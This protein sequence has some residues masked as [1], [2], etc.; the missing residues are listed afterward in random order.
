MPSLVAYQRPGVPAVA[1][2]GGLEPS[3]SREI[4]GYSRHAKRLQAMT[5]IVYPAMEAHLIS[6]L[7]RFPAGA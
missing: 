1:C 6:S 4:T 7:S 3:D 5:A 2:L